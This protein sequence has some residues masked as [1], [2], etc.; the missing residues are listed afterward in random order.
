MG[1]HLETPREKK[2]RKE[3]C[4]SPGAKRVNDQIQ[5]LSNPAGKKKKIPQRGPTN[6]CPKDEGGSFD[7]I[8]QPFSL[9]LSTLWSPPQ[10]PCP[11]PKAAPFSCLFG[12]NINK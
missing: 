1:A 8:P 12:E 10:E 6:H 4:K 9:H 11:N 3:G 7:P 2:K 5:I